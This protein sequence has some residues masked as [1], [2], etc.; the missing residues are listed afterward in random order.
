M[1]KIYLTLYSCQD[2]W[3]L[4]KSLVFLSLTL[5]KPKETT[6]LM[7]LQKTHSY[8]IHKPNLCHGPENCFL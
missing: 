4:L 3:L 1:S 8:G 7:S 6:L 2:L 5:W